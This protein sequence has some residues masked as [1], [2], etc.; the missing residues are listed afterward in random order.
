MLSLRTKTNASVSSSE[1]GTFNFPLTQKFDV[2]TYSETVENVLKLQNSPSL[3]SAEAR[4]QL[5]ALS[6]KK[7]Q[8]Y[9]NR[10]VSHKKK[11]LIFK[12]VRVCVCVF[13]ASYGH[14]YFG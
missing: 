9:S 13:A 5:P 2:S 12:Q 7:K 10:C 6:H 11:Q 8:S 3:L 14:V 4:Y 1:Y